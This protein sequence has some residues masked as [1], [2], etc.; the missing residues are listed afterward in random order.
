VAGDCSAGASLATEGDG[1]CLLIVQCEVFQ[2]GP[3]IR[4]PRGI[5]QGAI[6]FLI[7]SEHKAV[8][9]TVPPYW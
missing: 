3:Q 9:P 6:V 4:A 7:V 2:Q 5:T 1:P 8:T